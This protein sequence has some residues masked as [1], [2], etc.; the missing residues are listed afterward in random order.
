MTSANF[1]RIT[2]K[3]TILRITVSTGVALGVLIG[4]ANIA[5]AGEFNLDRYAAQPMEAP[6]LQPGRPDASQHLG[7]GGPARV[8]IAQ[9]DGTWLMLLMKP[10]G[11]SFVAGKGPAPFE[12]RMR[13]SRPLTSSF[14]PTASAES[15][16]RE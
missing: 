9:P 12:P 4:I 11:I 7:N 1:S 6:Q 2:F 14:T 5:K 16:G 15:Y 3:A 10:N 8:Y 13:E